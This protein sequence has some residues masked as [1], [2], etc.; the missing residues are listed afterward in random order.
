MSR[1]LRI[2]S[3]YGPH[4]RRLGVGAEEG[5]LLDLVPVPARA[6][7]LVRPDP[8]QRAA[9]RKPGTTFRAIAPA[10][11]RIAVSR[12]ES[13]RRRDSRGCRISRRR[14][15]RRGRGELLLDLAE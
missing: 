5:I 13:A 11:T 14:C 15:S 8:D 7:D 4:L 2:S 3:R 9:H 6:V 1:L 12:A 10:A